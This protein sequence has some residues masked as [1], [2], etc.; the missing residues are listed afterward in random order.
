MVIGISLAATAM[1]YSA[2]NGVPGGPVI[3]NAWIAA[4]ITLI[5]TIVFSVYLKG[6]WGQIS[7]LL[8]IVVGFIISI[9]LGLPDFSKIWDGNIFAVPH[10]TLPAV[11]WD[12][13][14]AIAPIAIATIWRIKK[15]RRGR[16]SQANWA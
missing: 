1:T 15:A 14:L 3:T 6:V 12:A 5:A 16:I 8:G 10:F 13:V 2:S 4:L 9:P 7:I 11:S